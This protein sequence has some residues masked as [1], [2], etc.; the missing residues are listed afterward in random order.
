MADLGKLVSVLLT[1]V[2]WVAVVLVL[3]RRYPRFLVPLVERMG[4]DT[5]RAVLAAF[6]WYATLMWVGGLLLVS[7]AD[8]PYHRPGLIAVLGVLTVAS[9]AF[10]VVVTRRWWRASAPASRLPAGID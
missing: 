1:V 3:T 7:P 10:A 5:R 9:A 4:R 8:H 6:G 2:F